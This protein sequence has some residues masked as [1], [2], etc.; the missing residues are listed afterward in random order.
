MFPAGGHR[1]G[2]GSRLIAYQFPAAVDS[3]GTRA[4]RIIL[5]RARPSFPR[6][7]RDCPP[8]NFPTLCS[9]RVPYRA[10]L[11]S[12]Y[13]SRNL[14]LALYEV[15][16]LA[17]SEC[18]GELTSWPDDGATSKAWEDEWLKSGWVRPD[19]PNLF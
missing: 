1:C 4:A 15:S 10:E 13:N 18:G 19:L 8:L 2:L 11:R 6:P 16:E 7:P 12:P 3:L 5:A 17:A 14:L 9:T